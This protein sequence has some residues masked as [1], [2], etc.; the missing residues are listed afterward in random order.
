[1]ASLNLRRFIPRLLTWQVLVLVLGLRGVDPVVH[2]LPRL[3]ASFRHLGIANHISQ[4]GHL[5]MGLDA[6]FNW[7]GF[8]TLLGMLSGATGVSDLTGIAAWAPVGIHVILL[9]LATRLTSTPRQ[10]WAGGSST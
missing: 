7:P 8:F 6:Y 3:E 1:V 10:A 9:A 4:S 5:N 2:G